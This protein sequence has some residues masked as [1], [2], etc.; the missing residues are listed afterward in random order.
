MQAALGGATLGAVDDPE[1]LRGRRGSIARDPRELQYCMP[2]NPGFSILKRTMV[3]LIFKQRESCS[4][5]V[6]FVGLL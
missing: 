1:V 3:V 2:E 6:C 4:Y 5:N